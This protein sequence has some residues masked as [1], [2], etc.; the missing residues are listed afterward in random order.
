[1]L[2]LEMT[3]EAPLPVGQL[4]YTATK[5]AWYLSIEPGA[6]C[7]G[8]MERKTTLSLGTVANVKPV[9][10]VLSYVIRTNVQKFY[11]T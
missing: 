9:M 5:S 8:I 3:S 1:M 2:R 6:F 10:R 7:M 4:K 11:L